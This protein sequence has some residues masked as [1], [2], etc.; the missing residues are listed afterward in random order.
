MIK[1]EV[2]PGLDQP[3]LR[4]PSRLARPTVAIMSAVDAAPALAAWTAFAWDRLHP[5]P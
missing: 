3:R 1:K 4:S 2:A 5:L